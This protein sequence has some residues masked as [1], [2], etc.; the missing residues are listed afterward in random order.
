MRVVLRSSATLLED[1]A[2]EVP[3]V[4]GVQQK[5]RREE[6]AEPRK[7]HHRHTQRAARRRTLALTGIHS[8]I[9]F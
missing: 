8:G 3:H 1:L 9:G 4:H 7:G 5:S 2:P 6:N